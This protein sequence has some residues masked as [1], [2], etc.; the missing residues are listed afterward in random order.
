MLKGVTV[1]KYNNFP[2]PL[3]KAMQEALSDFPLARSPTTNFPIVILANM[4]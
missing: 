2:T 1:K 3:S 4:P